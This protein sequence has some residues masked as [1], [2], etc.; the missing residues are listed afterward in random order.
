VVRL[1]A[2]AYCRVQADGRPYL[3]ADEG[4]ARDDHSA[5]DSRKYDKLVDALLALLSRE[6]AGPNRA[7]GHIQERA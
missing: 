5:H 4:Q 1:G 6:D 7:A 3:L 2:R